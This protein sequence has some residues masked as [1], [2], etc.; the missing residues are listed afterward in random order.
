MIT[1]KEMIEGEKSFVDYYL[2]FVTDPGAKDAL[3]KYITSR[4]GEGVTPTATD[5]L[6]RDFFIIRSGTYPTA[7]RAVEK[8]VDV[9]AIVAD[10]GLANFKNFQKFMVI[11]SMLFR[12]VF[13]ELEALIDD[14]I[15]PRD[16]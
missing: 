14:P 5:P 8:Y 11:N 6:L 7:F 9:D 15:P 3:M 13:P 16:S 4:L 10:S 1:H 2:Q 12:Y